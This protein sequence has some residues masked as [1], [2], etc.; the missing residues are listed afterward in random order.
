L[1]L[2]WD[3]RKRQNALQRRQLDFADVERFEP[4]S[5]RTE[6]DLRKD[7]GEPR[8]NSFGY[9]DSVLCTFCWT[10]RNGRV[11]IISMRK[12]NDRER[13]KYQAGSL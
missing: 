10:P 6:P 4:E 11:R 1:E 9:L 12:A 5:V 7:Y 13:K 8:F 2:E 3:E